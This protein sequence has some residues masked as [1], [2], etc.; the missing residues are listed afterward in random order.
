M[1][2]TNSLE[3][4]QQGPALVVVGLHQTQQLLEKLFAT[5]RIQRLDK[6]LVRG[7]DGGL[8]IA[9]H[10]LSGCRQEGAFGAPVFGIGFTPDDAARF[11]PGQDS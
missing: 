7:L 10:R 6:F 11:K 4:A 8:H 1:A 3:I 9:Q 2:Q 5:G